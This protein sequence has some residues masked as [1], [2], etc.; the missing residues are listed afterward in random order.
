MRD[1]EYSELVNSFQAALYQNGWVT[2]FDCGARQEVAAQYVESPGRI[3]FADAATLGMLLTTH[4][5]QERFC[6]G[7]LAAMFENGHIVAILRRLKEIRDEMDHTKSV[8]SY[9]DGLKELLSQSWS[10]YDRLHD[11][12]FVVRP[13]IPILYFGDSN[14]YF[15]S[16]LRVVTVGLNP[17]KAE[18]P[19]DERLSRFPAASVIPDDPSQRD[20]ECHLAALDAYFKTNCYW[21]WFS[22]YEPI[23]NGLN[24]S[25][26]DGY[27]SAA[28]HTDLCSPIATDPTWSKLSKDQKIG[29]QKD[30]MRI[31]HALI[32]TLQ[33]DIILVS[34]AKRYAEQ[35]AFPAVASPQ[36]I[37]KSKREKPF[38]VL[39]TL[40]TVKPLR[41]T[42]CVFG[43]AAQ[44]PFGTVSKS[45]KVEIGSAIK[46]WYNANASV[47]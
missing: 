15:S 43:K 19:D 34:V 28:L 21:T 14:R 16:P 38:Q 1:F 25:Y 5:R 37:W 6:D 47:H 35:I 31:W 3:T 10:A 26:R 42:V 44:T 33:P 17:S 32:K 24:A 45:N 23:L 11:Q 7:H 2:P 8:P 13:A 39:G 20:H 18:F 46:E 40:L 9:S 30:G 41:P 27:A 12:N 29:M 22:S 4:V 36:V